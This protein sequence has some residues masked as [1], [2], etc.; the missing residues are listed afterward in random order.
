MNRHLPAAFVDAT[1][2]T[3][4]YGFFQSPG[5]WLV[6]DLT[7]SR[8]QLTACFL[9]LAS[10]VATTA[11]AQT[12]DDVF[13]G[14]QFSFVPPGARSLATGGAFVGRADDATAAYSNPAGL[15]WLRQPEVSF[16]VRSANYTTE[17]LN[18]GRLA[19]TPTQVGDDLF[20]TPQ[21]SA[22]ERDTLGTSFLSY[23]RPAK[24]GKWALALFR[25]ELANFEVSIESQGLYAGIAPRV[26]KSG[27]LLGELDLLIENYGVAAALAATDNLWFGLGLSYYRIDVDGTTRRYEHETLFEPARFTPQQEFISRRMFG[28]DD[29]IALTGGLLWRSKSRRWSAGA[30]Y[31]QGPEFDVDST[32]T[33]G[34]LAIARNRVSPAL[35]ASRSGPTTFHTPDVL[36]A[37]ISVRATDALTVSF[38][39]DRVAYSNLEPEK[40]VLTRDVALERFEISDA[41]ELHLGVEYVLLKLR[42]PL[43][44]RGGA[45][46]DP[47][48]QLR[49]NGEPTDAFTVRYRAGDD[50]VH[51][52]GGLGLV[53]KDGRFQLDLA[54]DTSDRADIV[55]ISAVATL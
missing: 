53:L 48:H 51:L 24:N 10:L 28:D 50:V 43:V 44:L 7:V 36:G 32:F 18:G 33:F 55:T 26:N 13:A 49:F 37:G 39:F 19:D 45:W 38:D 22:F 34:P 31:R 16:E 9:G 11:F 3:P 54:F 47:D 5:S 27:S 25:H 35:A 17:Y 2:E 1:I 46:T 29:Q 14:L 6:S 40:N 23:A 42:T 8:N 15:L 41:D 52:T 30:V 21:F 4:W 20:S 12:N